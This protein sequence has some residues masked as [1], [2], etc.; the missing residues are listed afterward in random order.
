MSGMRSHA[1]SSTPGI[2]PTVVADTNFYRSCSDAQLGDL[3]ALE[4]TAGVRPK[5]TLLVCSEL[6][7]HVNSPDA[8]RARIYSAAV[9][10]LY[11]HCFADHEWRGPA[12]FVPPPN[13]LLAQRIFG[14]DPS[15]DPTLAITLWGMV[16]DVAGG[17]PTGTHPELREA[18][19]VLTR[20]RDELEAKF[21]A[22]LVNVR[23]M[24]GAD[25]TTPSEFPPDQRPTPDAFVY[26]P[27]LPAIGA[28][29]LVRNVATEYGIELDDAK[30]MQLGR[31]LAP[32]IPTA[33]DF[34]VGIVRKVVLEGASPAN[35]GNSLWD[36]H[37]ATLAASGL[38][39]EEGPVLLVTNDQEIV[40]SAQRTG[41]KERVLTPDA[42]EAY[43]RTRSDEM[44]H[45]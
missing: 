16:S 22:M 32:H 13:A 19:Q 5:P 18:I 12:N 34:F 10:R 28:G 41:A 3:R 20:F 37:F 35:Q 29:S 43:L 40:A 45:P 30:T 26:G 7:P 2:A 36:M 38:R 11:T 42:Y 25:P 6:L 21:V 15:P 31:E 24:V 14:I 8:R 1:V 4:A 39:F 44:G 9:R 33:L 27:D 17:I 23:R